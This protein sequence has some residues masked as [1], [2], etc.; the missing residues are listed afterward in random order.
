MK[1]EF[2]NVPECDRR[3]T[4]LFGICDGQKWKEEKPEIIREGHELRQKS[5]RKSCPADG[6]ERMDYFA[7]VKENTADPP[8]SASS[9]NL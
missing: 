8:S 7:K 9:R 6:A 2:L 1:P 5:R 3:N 4:G